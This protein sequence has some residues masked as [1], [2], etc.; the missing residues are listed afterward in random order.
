MDSE[1][2]EL[3]KFMWLRDILLHCVPNR[4][5]SVI[6]QTSTHMKEK[7]KP[8]FESWEYNGSVDVLQPL[9]SSV[10]S[11]EFWRGQIH[12]LFLST[13]APVISTC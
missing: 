13:W 9:V 11:I 8:V 1:N 5:N 7:S 6:S 4:H 12:G 10:H 2:G 3:K